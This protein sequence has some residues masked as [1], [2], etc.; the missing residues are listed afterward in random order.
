MRC[1]G[2]RDESPPATRGQDATCRVGESPSERETRPA[3]IWKGAW[4][5]DEKTNV[6]ADDKMMSADALQNMWLHTEAHVWLVALN[7]RQ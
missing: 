3:L 6:S 7:T 2:P 4:K 1:P 5:G